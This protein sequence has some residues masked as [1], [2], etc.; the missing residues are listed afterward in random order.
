MFVEGTVES[1]ALVWIFAVA[2]SRNARQRQR[3]GTR[4]F[5]LLVEVVCD[6]PVVF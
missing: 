6:G 5:L 3:E 4:S 2:Q 1:R